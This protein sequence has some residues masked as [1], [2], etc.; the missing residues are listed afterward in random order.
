MNG[1]KNE[2]TMTLP[3]ETEQPINE[4]SQRP[5]EELAGSGVP[6]DDVFRSPLMQDP[7]VPPT[8]PDILPSQTSL[9]G[10]KSPQVAPS[11]NA[12]SPRTSRITPSLLAS[13]LQND[14]SDNDVE[15]T[16]TLAH[17]EPQIRR[18]VIRLL[19]EKDHNVY[20]LSKQTYAD[21]ERIYEHI[22]AMQLQGMIDETPGHKYHLNSK[23]RSVARIPKI[24]PPAEQAGQ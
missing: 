10:A 8:H 15:F 20:T 9:V 13:R 14:R 22:Y 16:D 1:R 7:P 5:E 4:E 17:V 21:M 6:P 23:G 3:M 18:D 12:F 19:R 11:P 2:C 24:A